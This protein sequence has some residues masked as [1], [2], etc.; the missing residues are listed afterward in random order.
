M[1][2]RGPRTQVL[3]FLFLCGRG[4]AGGAATGVPPQ[5]VPLQVCKCSLGLCSKGHCLRERGPAAL[6]RGW[7]GPGQPCPP[8]PLKE[9]HLLT[10]LLAPHPHIHTR[11]I[12]SHFFPG[13]AISTYA[14]YCYHKLQKAALTGAKKV[15]V[16]LGGW[17]GQAGTQTLGGQP[18]EP[19]LQFGVGQKCRGCHTE[20]T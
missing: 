20:P 4:R 7:L 14:K 15:R 12:G 17:G 10:P 2:S 9:L 16:R 18:Q 6:G 8:G 19:C 3:A 1:G 5:P 11:L 13:V